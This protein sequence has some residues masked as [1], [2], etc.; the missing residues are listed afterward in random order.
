MT[1]LWL[2]LTHAPDGDEDPGYVHGVFTKRSAALSAVDY[3][4]HVENGARFEGIEES[5]SN[6]V[7][8]Y[9]G[10]VIAQVI[11]ITTNE[12]IEIDV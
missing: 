10:D 4:E 12:E 7:I 1:K 6:V 11:R 5:N 2:A 9:G 3:D 8:G